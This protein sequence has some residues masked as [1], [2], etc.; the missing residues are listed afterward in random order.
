MRVCKGP[1]NHHSSRTKTDFISASLLCFIRTEFVLFSRVEE[2]NIKK[3]S[4]TRIY[5]IAAWMHKIDLFDHCSLI[6][7]LY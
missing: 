3:S 5:G 1:R 6:K 4:C 2:R 7:M